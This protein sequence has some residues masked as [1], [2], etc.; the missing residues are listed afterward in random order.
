MSQWMS[1]KCMI[2]SYM[3]YGSYR[4]KQMAISIA[5]VIFAAEKIKIGK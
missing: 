3:Q 4:S 5:S 2:I 1:H